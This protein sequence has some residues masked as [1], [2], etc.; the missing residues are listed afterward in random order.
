MPVAGWRGRFSAGG[1][2]LDQCVA[3]AFE[4]C[5]ERVEPVAEGLTGETTQKGSR[6]M[7]VFVTGATGFVGSFVVA[8]L[9]SAI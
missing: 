1:R 6:R 5:D 9:I 7:R 2:V 4:E 8:E 3:G